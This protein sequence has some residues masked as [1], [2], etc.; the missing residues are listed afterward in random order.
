MVRATADGLRAAQRALH[1]AGL[2]DT[3]DVDATG[4]ER[5]LLCSQPFDRRGSG[6]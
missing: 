3:G 6:P 4:T 2:A 5:L 1:H